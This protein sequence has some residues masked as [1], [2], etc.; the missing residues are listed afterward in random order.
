MNAPKQTFERV[1]QKTPTRDIIN[2]NKT[3]FYCPRCRRQMLFL[4]Q[5][6]TEVKKLPVWC[7]TCKREVEVN[8]PL[9]HCRKT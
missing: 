9:S 4:I 2:A 1:L 6:D 5:A 8:I 7:K 3:R